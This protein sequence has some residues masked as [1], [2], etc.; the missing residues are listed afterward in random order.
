[1][2]QP[3]YPKK[4]KPSYSKHE[5]MESPM[6]EGME[7]NMKKEPEYQSPLARKNYKSGKGWC[8]PKENCD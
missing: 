4:D 5:K 1:M 7:K 6:A 3:K 2:Q 8:G